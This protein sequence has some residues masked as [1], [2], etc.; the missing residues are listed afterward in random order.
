[1]SEEVQISS[2][3]PLHY[4]PRWLR[5]KP[6][7]RPSLL[8]EARTERQR[9]PAPDEGVRRAPASLD[10]E[11]ESAVYESLLRPL[12]PRIVDGPPEV[13][14]ELDRGRAL[15]GVA[16]RFGAAIGISAIVALFFVFMVRALPQRDSSSPL[17]AAVQK[18][19]ATVVPPQR[20]DEVSEPELAAFRPLL[21]QRNDPAV[22][23]KES[24]R[25]LRQFMQ[26]RQGYA[27]TNTSR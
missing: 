14:R 3:D 21:T 24:Q 11:L 25:L 1:M 16:A 4:A 8:T 15:F 6:E 13:G 10:A 27:S 23:H 7:Q 22:A 19:E 26:W 18:V 2:Q 20:R 5:E 17:A 12:D 9:V